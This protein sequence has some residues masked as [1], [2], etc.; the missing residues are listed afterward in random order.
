MA[1]DLFDR[2]L[3]VAGNPES[4]AQGAALLALKATGRAAS[5]AAAVAQLP[6]HTRRV[7]PDAGIHARYASLRPVFNG[8]PATLAPFYAKLAAFQRENR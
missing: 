2:P 8:V 4:T 5:L 6:E 3:I 1:A 7:H